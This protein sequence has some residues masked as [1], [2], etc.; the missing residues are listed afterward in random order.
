MIDYWITFISQGLYWAVMIMLPFLCHY[1]TIN[2]TFFRFLGI[3]ITCFLFG[4]LL[5][6]VLPASMIPTGEIQELNNIIVPIGLILMLLSSDFNQWIKVS[7]TMLGGYLLGVLSVI[8]MCIALF[9]IFHQT[10]NMAFITG[11]LA[12][13]YIGGTPN[14][15]AVKIAFSIPDTIYNQAFLCDVLASSVYLLFM[16][17]FSAR[18]LGWVL[19]KG[20]KHNDEEA[21]SADVKEEYTLYKPALKIFSGIFLAIFIF[22]IPVALW[23]LMVGSI[24]NMSM[25]YVI[26][27]ITLLS[28]GFSFIKKIRLNNWNFKTGNYI[29]SLFFGLLGSLTHFSELYQIPWYLI[30]YTFLILFGSVGIHI[31]FCRLAGISR[32]I[33]IIT[34]AAGIMSPPF[35]PAIASSIKNKSL[36]VPGIAVGVIGLAA[37][38]V[39][40]IFMVKLLLNFIK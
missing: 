29:F 33:M 22:I 23:W 28:V 27:M 8:I 10:E 14:M 5:G 26:L 18:V 37:G 31:I 35:I 17:V 16:M 7:F 30:G 36:I 32:D 24:K 20:T 6:N 25:V 34:S 9:F 39:L 40:G 15:A 13:T 3:T 38:N 11:M 1:L 19:K 4:V 12:A 2:S 21:D